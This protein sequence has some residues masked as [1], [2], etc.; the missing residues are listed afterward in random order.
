MRK[1]PESHLDRTSNIESKFSDVLRNGRSNVDD[2][3][4]VMQE[5]GKSGGM[6]LTIPLKMTFF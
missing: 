4:F 3:D 5:L 2:T 1:K 6:C